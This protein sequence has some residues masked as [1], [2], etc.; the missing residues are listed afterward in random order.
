MLSS[1]ML[2]L[3]L[4]LLIDVTF[5]TVLMLT[6]VHPRLFATVTLKSHMKSGFLHG[7]PRYGFGSVSVAT[8]AREDAHFVPLGVTQRVAREF[9]AGASFVHESLKIRYGEVP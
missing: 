6:S 4:I 5:S 1:N 7:Q 3:N 2:L 8:F 9:S